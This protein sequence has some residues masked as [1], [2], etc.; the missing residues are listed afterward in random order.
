[1]VVSKIIL[2]KSSTSTRSLLKWRYDDVIMKV[3]GEDEIQTKCRPKINLREVTMKYGR[4][5]VFIRHDSGEIGDLGMDS[6]LV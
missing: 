3:G 1:L 5:V 2:K 6:N 4:F